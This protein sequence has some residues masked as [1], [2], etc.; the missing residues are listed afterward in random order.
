MYTPCPHHQGPWWRASRAARVTCRPGT[1]FISD[2]ERNS[3][4]SKR[5]LDG[6]VDIKVYGAIAV[7]SLRV[8]VTSNSNGGT[9]KVFRNLRIFWRD[10]RTGNWKLQMWFNA[11]IPPAS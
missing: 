7:A 5:R 3:Q 11:Q 2:L 10:S 6:A 1:A 9:Q 4:S 8:A